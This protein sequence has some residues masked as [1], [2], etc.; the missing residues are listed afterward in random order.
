MTLL[1]TRL[2]C[3]RRVQIFFVFIFIATLLQIRETPRSTTNCRDKNVMSMFELA[4][5]IKI[6]E[7][8]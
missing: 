2:P 4:E 7:C 8:R 3:I 5:K 6:D 1:Q